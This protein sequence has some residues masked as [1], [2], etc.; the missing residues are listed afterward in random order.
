MHPRSAPTPPGTTRNGMPFMLPFSPD[1]IRWRRAAIVELRKLGID[2]QPVPARPGPASD[3]RPRSDQRRGSPGPSLRVHGQ[4]KRK[5]ATDLTF[6]DEPGSSN[7]SCAQC[8]ALRIRHASAGT[9]SR[10]TATSAVGRRPPERFAHVCHRQRLGGPAARAHE[11]GGDNRGPR[12]FE[13]S[14]RR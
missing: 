12:G 6:P 5:T 14:R 10:E 9:E 1:T 13:G 11:R 2:V 7:V 8:A 4:S 3:Q